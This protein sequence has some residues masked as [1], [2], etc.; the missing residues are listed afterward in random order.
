M[1]LQDS[2]PDV[3]L[4]QSSEIKPSQ[5]LTMRLTEGISEDDE[6]VKLFLKTEKCIDGNVF[7]A[8]TWRTVDD[9]K[10]QGIS[11]PKS[12]DAYEKRRHERIMA[13]ELLHPPKRRRI[14]KTPLICSTHKTSLRPGT[15]GCLSCITETWIKNFAS[16]SSV[17]KTV[18]S[19]GKE[20]STRKPKTV[21]PEI[22][23][24][25]E[26]K[27]WRRLK[28]IT[29]ADSN[30]KRAKRLKMFEVTEG[31]NEDAASTKSL[32]DPDRN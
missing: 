3:V 6:K 1:A 2:L 21:P 24:K 11:L 30:Y 20:P 31:G 19:K 15:L 7:R 9:V 18:E 4:E 10:L 32:S 29:A 28:H 17:K 8:I 23:D 14:S 26:L 5:V 16:V 25:L 13:D 22:V 12:E 27:S